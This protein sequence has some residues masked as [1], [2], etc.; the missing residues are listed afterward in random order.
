MPS[1]SKF[2]MSL[3][4]RKCMPRVSCRKERERERERVQAGSKLWQCFYISM[5]ILL[6]NCLVTFI[7]GANGS[8]FIK[9]AFHN[10][11]NN[12]CNW[13]VT[14]WQWLFYMYTKYEIGY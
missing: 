9:L 14:R 4:L 6:C 11:N 8:F 10:N 12:N 7:D 2:Y 13:V 5:M 1:D 3:S